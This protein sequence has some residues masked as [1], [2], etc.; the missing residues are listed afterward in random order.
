MP[1]IRFIVFY[2]FLTTGILSV[3]LC[4]PGL[5]AKK[6][7]SDRTFPDWLREYHAWDVYERELSSRT[8]SPENLLARG[9]SLLRQ[10][11][12]EEIISLLGGSFEHPDHEQRRLLLL[13]RA[14]R[15]AGA[16]QEC[17]FNWLALART[18][19]LQE[20][21]KTMGKEHGLGLLFEDVW[22][23]WFWESFF[24]QNP[25]LY[26]TRRPMM[27]QMLDLG[28]SAWP[29]NGF[30]KQIRPV[31]TDIS[32][33]FPPSSPLSLS[34]GTDGE[35]I[36]RTLAAWSLGFW[37]Q[38]DAFLDQ[39]TDLR[40]SRFWQ[41]FAVLIGR[42]SGTGEADSSDQPVRDDF[43]ALFAPDIRGITRWVLTPPETPSWPSFARRLQS[44]DPAEALTLIA[45]E[46]DSLFLPEDIR[47]TLALCA[48]ALKLQTGEM[49]SIEMDRN[50]PGSQQP[51]PPLLLQMA[52]MILGG[53]SEMPENVAEA[54]LTR[55]LLAAAK[56]PS[57]GNVIADFWG[58]PEPENVYPLDYLKGYDRL[59][60]QMTA[61]PDQ[62]IAGHLAFLYPQSPA[63]QKALLFLARNANTN[64]NQNL[65]WTYLQKIRTRD[66]DPYDRIE[67]LLARAGMEMELG[68]EDAAL[69]DYAVLMEERPERIPPEKQLKLALLG[70]QKRQWTWAQNILESL[71]ERRAT[72]EEPLRAEILFWLGEG[73]Q[74]QGRMQEALTCYLRLAWSYPKQNIWAVTAMYRAGLIYEKRR[75]FETAKRLYTTVLKQSD[76]KSQKEAA[77]TR[78]ASVN[79]DMKKN[80]QT[81]PM[82]LF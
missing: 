15:L 31:F 44:M 75:E 42:P 80:T 41:R 64:G 77:R 48:T 8:N 50:R 54:I 63:A 61:K 23:Q 19:D 1:K 76:R 18:G 68:Q 33:L 29:E 35:L 62:T 71:W 58:Q 81:L 17:I 25:V 34:L 7:S 3:L 47:R 2:F 6:E 12:P 78:I 69:K 21:V 37:E 59:A 38:G 24:T 60:A 14:N 53:S 57:N 27:E 55:Y 13:A 22:K 74:S 11:K 49:E 32:G 20:T 10:N 9:E 43:F 72:L 70:Q 39:V 65:A 67:F 73:A 36:G 16:Y 26:D 28:E 52:C 66:L 82:P 4:A 45:T 56:V 46:Q 30:W 5:A 40:V 79:A 51:A